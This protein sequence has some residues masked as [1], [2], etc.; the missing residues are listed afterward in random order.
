MSEGADRSDVIVVGAGIVGLACALAAQRQGFR[1]TL[2]DRGEPAA[3]TSRGNAGGIATSDILPL[4][5]PGIIRKAPRWLLD[6]LGPLSIHPRHAARLAPW[7][8]RFWRA[9]G[10]AQVARSTAALAALNGLSWQQTLPLYREAGVEGHL[11]QRGSIQLYESERAFRAAAPGWTV[12]AKH[13]IAFEH[14]DRP[15]LQRLEPALAPLFPRATFVPGWCH[16]SDPYRIGQAFA[17]HIRKR[18]G[19]IL[20][21]SVA[22]IEPA[23]D[24]KV[25]LRLADDAPL[26]ANRLVVAAGAWSHLLSRQLGEPVPLET[27]RGYN[28]TLPHPGVELDRMLIFGDDGFVISPLEIGLRVGGRVELGGLDL[29]PDHRRTRAMLAKAKRALPGLDTSGGDV[30]MGF[31]PSLPD[32]L[33]VLG[34]SGRHPN[35]L[36]AF[37]HGHLGLTQAPATGHLIGQL[38]RDEPPAIDLAPFRVDRF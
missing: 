38:L 17:A 33:P 28:T 6:P 34:R 14:L 24:N 26:E 11:H 13:G 30:W 7:L 20:R 21:G 5:S 12:R 2:I 25:R 32:S 29:P 18:G 19:R 9:S 3:A 36:Y 10:P 37:G 16:V 35:V 23:S 27:E 15:Q 22:G 4:A 8:W 31:R 1:V